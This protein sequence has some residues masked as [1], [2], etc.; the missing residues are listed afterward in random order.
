MCHQMERFRS[1]KTGGDA[2]I[3]SVS[4]KKSSISYQ[5]TTDLIIFSFYGINSRPSRPNES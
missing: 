1:F 3:V 5:K 4:S 2:L